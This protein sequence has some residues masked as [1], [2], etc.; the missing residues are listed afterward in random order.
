MAAKP[1]SDSGVR[2]SSLGTAAANSLA[3]SDSGSSS[4]QCGR[5]V[6]NTTQSTPAPARNAATSSACSSANSENKTNTRTTPCDATCRAIPPAPPAERPT[7]NT[8]PST[9]GGP[10]AHRR[11][12]RHA[13]RQQREQ[14]PPRCGSLR[15]RSR[16]SCSRGTPQAKKLLLQRQRQADHVSLGP[17]QPRLKKQRVNEGYTLHFQHRIR[18]HST[19][20]TQL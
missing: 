17:V 1:I 15:A 8:T 10:P 18:H 7:T 11:R 9:T 4:F 2:Y 14:Q 16:H 13:K 19:S 20:T 3:V 5:L 6:A 12:Q